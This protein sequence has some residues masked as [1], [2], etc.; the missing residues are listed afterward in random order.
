M[1]QGLAV[2]R[3]RPGQCAKALRLGRESVPVGGP[4]D[5][6]R[7]DAEPVAGPEDLLGLG[8]PDDEGEHAA[9]L[10]DPVGAVVVVAG[11]DGLAVTLGV[12]YR[13]V[14]CAQSGAQFDVVVDLAVEHHRVAIGVLGRPP[15][16]RLVGP[17][18]VDDAES[19]EA[20]GNPVVVPD[21]GV[22]G[23]SVPGASHTLGDLRDAFVVQLS[24]RDEAHQAAHVPFHR[25]S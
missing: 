10:L 17:F 15:T 19:I 12:E 24:C 1:R 14:V 18:D 16:Q 25:P 9:Q 2:D 3:G 22:V 8:V 7:L 23:A 21:G 4:G 5:V 6:Q 11:H 20:H 13:V